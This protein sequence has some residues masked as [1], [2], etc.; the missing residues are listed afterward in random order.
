MNEFNISA[1]SDNM[2]VG[3]DSGGRFE[4]LR[5]GGVAPVKYGSG[6]GNFI[7]FK[8]EVEDDVVESEK[9]GRQIFKN[10]A[11]VY[12][13]APGGKEVH[14]RRISFNKETQEYEDA[15]I[16]ANPKK[17]DAFINNKPVVHD[18][19]PLYAWGHPKM[20]GARI[21]TFQ[22]GSIHTVQQL[23]SIPDGAIQKF[24]P[25]TREL[26]NA[27]K[28]FMAATKDS[29]V[30]NKQR[31]EI[32]ALRAE[33]AATRELIAEAGLTKAVQKVKQT[34]KVKQTTGEEENGES[35]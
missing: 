34:K 31:S 13:H 9:A 4:G 29:A 1:E 18:G 35:I 23:A 28:D 33:L 32:E 27:A 19:M 10:V 24:G 2:G 11:M 5:E 26:V 21:K 7:E 25:G 15:E 6:S 16:W 22:V 30:L 8:W 14:P 3:Y 20:D 12:I 17:W